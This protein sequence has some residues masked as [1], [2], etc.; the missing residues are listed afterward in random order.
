MDDKSIG[1]HI[2][3]LVA[4]EHRLL[5]SGENGGMKAEDHTRL[6][7]VNVELDRYWDLLRQ[8]RAREEFGQDP[9]TAKERSANVVEK[10]QQ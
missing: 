2:E 1:K 6:A 10:Y 8:R 7:Q 5:E 9:D 3:E 4:E